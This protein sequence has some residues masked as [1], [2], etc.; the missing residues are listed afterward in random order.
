MVQHS[1]EFI[2]TVVTVEVNV[3]SGVQGQFKM[4]QD[5]HGWSLRLRSAAC[6]TKERYGAP[7]HVYPHRE[8]LGT[9][10]SPAHKS[11]LTDFAFAAAVDAF[12]G[13]EV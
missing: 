6:L 8:E 9:P 2:R 13:F 1:S 3:C 11:D 10:M 5:R 12:N 7:E 4:V